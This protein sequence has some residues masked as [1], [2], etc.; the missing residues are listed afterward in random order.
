MLCAR[1]AQRDRSNS[2]GG[3]A[4]GTEKGTPEL[5]QEGGAEAEKWSR[6]ANGRCNGSNEGQKDLKEVL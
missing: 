5:R 6:G 1:A 4:E 3:G 2:C